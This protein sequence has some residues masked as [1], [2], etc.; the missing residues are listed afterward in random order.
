M[1]IERIA[2]MQDLEQRF[3][4]ISR[5]PN[6]SYYK[7][8]Y[9]QVRPAPILTLGINP[10]G[11][12]TQTNFEGTRHNSGA[13]ASSSATF[14]ENDECDLLDCE[15]PE[16][17][18]LR[19]LLVPLLRGNAALIRD[20]VVKTNLAFRRSAKSQQIDRN[21]A[22]AEAAPF[23]QEIISIV[24]PKLVL[25]TGAPL[26]NFGDFFGSH[27]KRVAEPERDDKVKQIVFA[28]DSLIL[29]GIDSEALAVQLAHASQFGWT[30]ERYRVVD[31]ITDLIV[32]RYLDLPPAAHTQS[33][34]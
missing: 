23:L 14:F 6:R 32:A 27:I 10:G 26:K 25:L 5:L 31:R 8:F 13:I 21:A 30:Y 33:S 18:G 22:F 7:I 17:Q 20:H 16:N 15:W 4:A 28:A 19:S 11:D 12:P 2:F 24:R 9:G 1:T 3:K 34:D 29:R